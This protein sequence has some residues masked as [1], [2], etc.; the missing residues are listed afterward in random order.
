MEKGKDQLGLKQSVPQNDL[1]KRRPQYYSL[2]TMNLLLFAC[3]FLLLQIKPI[4]PVMQYTISRR[5]GS[6]RTQ[7]DLYGDRTVKQS[8][9]PAEDANT[10][11]ILIKAKGDNYHGSFRVSLTDEEDK[12]IQVWETDKLD[13]ASG[14]QGKEGWISF[15]T[16]NIS[17]HKRYAITVSAPDLDK[18]TAIT[19]A[20]CEKESDQTD[21]AISDCETE[22]ETTNV[23]LVF[24]VAKK[25]TNYLF[26]AAVIILF[27]TANLWWFRRKTP[28]KSALWI[29]LGTGLIMLLIMAPGSQPDEIYHYCSSYKLSNI[30]LGEKE[31]INLAARGMQTRYE[32]HYNDNESF[33]KLFR[34]IGGGNPDNN[35]EN[36]PNSQQE[37]VHLD[38]SDELH[39]PIAYLPQALGIMTVRLLGGNQT[40]A[41]TAARF[42]NLLSYILMCWISIRLAPRNKQLFLLICILPMAMHQAAS[43]SRDV[44]V[45]GMSL[46]FMAYLF[47]LIDSRK[48]ITVRHILTFIFLLSLFGPVK[49]GYSAFAFLV[50]FI[51]KTQFRNGKDKALKTGFV[52]LTITV[53]IFLSEWALIQKK[54]TASDYA[55]KSDYYHIGYIIS[56]PLRYLRL[57]LNSFEQLFWKHTEEAAGI[58]LAGLSLNIS[59]Y[60]VLIYIALLFLNSTAADQEEQWLTK[61]QRIGLILFSILCYIFTIITFSFSDTPYGN[62]LT[63][64]IQ[65]RYLIPLVAPFFYGISTRRITLHFE[66][67]R[68]MYAVWFVELGYI[69]SVMSQIRFS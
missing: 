20:T 40:Q 46:V 55:G 8:F 62:T 19:V 36:N 50:L 51:P 29:L 63:E 68:L 34:E 64:G 16:S 61:G 3:L 60:L 24:S 67:H 4:D 33:A 53:V 10:F 23:N 27:L 2:L 38:R 45:N 31:N 41:Y 7:V 42:F 28:E 30:I 18:E 25:Q 12:E 22:G 56:H 35:P 26:Y 1:R 9:V 54:L 11:E 65:G 66:K 48:Q 14:Q 43:T 52:I 6:G 13:L 15:S 32:Q 59:E 49:V 69:V 5:N 21:E 37:Q 44:F 57:I 47:Q 17:K 39:F 58:K